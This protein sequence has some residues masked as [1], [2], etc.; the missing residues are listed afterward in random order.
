MT[1][2]SR[3]NNLAWGKENYGSKNPNFNGGR[4]VDDKGYIR[5]LV[6]DHPFNNNGYIY[7][8]RLVA[9]KFLGRFLQTWETIHHINEVKIDNRWENFYLT[10]ISEHSSIHREGKK[11]SKERR[12]KTSDRAKQRMKGG[13]RNSGGRFEKTLPESDTLDDN[14]LEGLTDETI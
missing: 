1:L 10:T 6:P 3:R 5:V 14:E 8:H 7:E 4:Y 9:E 2:A 12:K 13:K 11:Q